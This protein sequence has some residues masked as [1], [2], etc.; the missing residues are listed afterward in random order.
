MKNKKWIA[1]ILGVCAALSLTG[2]QL[3]LENGDG[4]QRGD[5]LIGALVTTEY[6]DLFDLE[7][8]LNDHLNGF[9]GG[10]I[11]ADGNSADYQGRLYA[12]L[13]TRTVTDQQTRERAQLQEFVFEDMDGAAYFAARIPETETE[14]SFISGGSDEAI[15]DGHMGLFY[16]DEEDKITLEGTIYIVPDNSGKTYYINPVYQSGD[17]SV[18]ATTGSGISL[19][20][21][22]DEGEAF[23]QTLD[24]TIT[25]TENGKSKSAVT[26]VTISVNAMLAPRQIVIAQMDGNGTRISRKEYAPGKLPETLALD[27][28]AAYI[29]VETQ[30]QNRAGEQL[31]SRALYNAGE[32]SIATFYSREDGICVKQWTRLLWG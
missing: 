6:L 4:E 21:V 15:S 13:T 24:E 29:I 7:G 9:S 5:R 19:G 8:Y 16:G 17:G 12:T 11:K 18:Y 25:V 23:S 1:L 20:G 31:V 28:E 27:K 32:E 3:A 22:M 10:E 30:K 14:D 26:S 2:C